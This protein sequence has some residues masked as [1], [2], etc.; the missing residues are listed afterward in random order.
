MRTPNYLPDLH[1]RKV[2]DALLL[3]SVDV[4]L[5]D[6]SEWNVTQ[7]TAAENWAFAVY[8]HASDNVLNGFCRAHDED[9]NYDP[10]FRCICLPPKPEFLNKYKAPELAKAV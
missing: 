5:A 3:A 10:P 6:I 1:P 2:R 8:L 9:A 4:P 7:L